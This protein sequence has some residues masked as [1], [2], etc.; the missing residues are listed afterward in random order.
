MVPINFNSL[1]FSRFTVL[2]EK[3]T[4]VYGQAEVAKN[5]SFFTNLFIFGHIRSILLHVNKEFQC[6]LPINNVV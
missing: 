1:T 6:Y 3:I 4:I 5:F 2:V